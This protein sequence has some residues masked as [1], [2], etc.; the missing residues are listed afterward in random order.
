M[1]LFWL[2]MEWGGVVLALS[3]AYLMSKNTG[4][5]KKAWCIFLVADL[6]HAF[7]YMHTDQVGLV[8]NQSI[9][10]VIALLG[11]TVLCNK[12]NKILQTFVG[13]LMNLMIAVFAAISLYFGVKWAMSPS[14]SNLEWVAS[15]VSLTGTALMASTNKY[16]RFGFF[17]WLFCD[18]SMLYV[19]ILKS[20]FGIILLRV[21]YTI[22][23]F[24]GIK[25]RF[26]S[27]INLP[28]WKKKQ[29]VTTDGVVASY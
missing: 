17:G 23:D 13:R 27:K 28:I 22:I 8:Y 1:S 21:I 26:F 24:N 2:F 18:L 25:Q 3:A 29:V 4:Q 6:T 9:G 12:E 11:L 10:F 15:F 20:Q 7:Y 19:A 5:E 16:A 14:V